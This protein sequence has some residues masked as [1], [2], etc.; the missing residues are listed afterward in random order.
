[1][2]HILYAIE[3]LGR[4]CEICGLDGFLEPWSMDFDHK[5][6][7]EKIYEVKNI[8]YGGSFHKHKEEIDKCRLICCKCHRKQHSSYERYEKYNTSILEKLEDIKKNNGKIHLVLSDKEKNDIK[9]ELKKGFKI[10]Q[11]AKNLNL[12]YDLVKHYIRRNT[13]DY[14]PKNQVYYLR[15]TIVNLLNC[16]YSIRGIAKKLDINRETIR[17]LIKEYIG[18]IECARGKRYFVVEQQGKRDKKT[19]KLIKNEI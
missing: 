19:R 7:Y 2:A 9:N 17:N 15:Y 18:I 16:K 11:V 6:E 13:N 14:I 4:Y 5:P 3:Y 12:N 1:M 10:W 8:L